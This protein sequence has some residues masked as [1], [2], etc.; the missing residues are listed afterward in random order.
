[1]K[2]IFKSYGCLLATLLFMPLLQAQLLPS[3]TQGQGIVLIEDLMPLCKSNH[4]T[5]LGYISSTDGKVWMVPTDS[6]LLHAPILYDLYN[7]CNGFMP[8]TL[9]SVSTSNVPV[10][11]IDEDG[12]VITGFLFADNY[13][14]FYING[15]LIGVD[16]VPFTPFNSS[17]V[18]FKVKRPYTIAVKLVDWEEHVGLGSEIQNANTKYH[19]GDGGFI[20]QFSDGTVTDA[21]WKTQC[22]YI[23]PLASPDVVTELASGVHSTAGVTTNPPFEDKCYGLHYEIP[24]DWT[25]PAYDDASW[26]NAFLYTAAQ[27]TN[28]A[29]YTNFA[30]DAWKNANFIWSSNLI[31][32]N[33]VLTKKTVGGET[34]ASDITNE[35]VDVQISNPFTDKLV[36]HTNQNISKATI[37]LINTTGQIVAHWSDENISANESHVIPLGNVEIAAGFYILNISN[38]YCHY[39][40]K[41]YKAHQ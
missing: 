11:T 21:T 24:M 6:T 33:V 3:V 38:Q 19:A 15:I 31:L 25:S 4:T 5:P 36:L 40:I 7:Q 1:M 41:L 22:F 9:S 26:P 23:A 29:A 8:L 10:T 27:V 30:N 13:F 2:H 32:D 20:A 14:E 18:K 35:K 39:S 34:L 37:A 16:A 12:E 28:Q 17:I